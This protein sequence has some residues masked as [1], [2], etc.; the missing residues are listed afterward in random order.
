MYDS[1]N[2]K[3]TSDLINSYAWDTA[4]LYIQKCGNNG[5]DSSKYSIQRGNSAISTSARQLTGGNKLAYEPGGTTTR[6]TAIFDTQCNIFDMAGNVREWSTESINGSSAR[7]SS[8][9]GLYTSTG[10]TCKRDEFDL[11][12]TYYNTTQMYFI[13]GFR[14]ILYF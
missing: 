12:Y 1:T 10:T 3:V 13:V 2:D 8:R 4:I 9:G 14:V 5:N 6:E 7:C 11:S